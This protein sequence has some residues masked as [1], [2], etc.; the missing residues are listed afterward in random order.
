MQYAVDTPPPPP[1]VTK[2][3]PG[4]SPPPPPPPPWSASLFDRPP[5]DPACHTPSPL[6]QL[7]GQTWHDQSIPR[8]HKRALGM[9]HAVWRPASPSL[10][11]RLT[12]L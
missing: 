10:T 11:L 9:A 5:R 7:C 1:I 3:S 8:E 6:P 4:T 2:E 12:A